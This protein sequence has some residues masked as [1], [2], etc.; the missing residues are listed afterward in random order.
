MTAFTVTV[1]IATARGATIRDAVSGVSKEVTQNIR[2]PLALAAGV[3]ALGAAGHTMRLCV[4]GRQT[5]GAG[6]ELFTEAI[7]DRGGAI[8]GA[9][10]VTRPPA[11]KVVIRRCLA[12][13]PGPTMG[14]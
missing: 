11:L 12:Y 10:T 6:F 8:D 9:V 4:T 2:P 1:R 3:D 14:V 7:I 13:H 5:D